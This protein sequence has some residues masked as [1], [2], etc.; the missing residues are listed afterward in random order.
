MSNFVDFGTVDT[1]G[2]LEKNLMFYIETLN[3]KKIVL[4]RDC[5]DLWFKKFNAIFELFICS[6]V[7]PSLQIAIPSKGLKR[8]YFYFKI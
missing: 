1:L 5:N 4:S 8:V 3:L 7:I 2:T 6:T